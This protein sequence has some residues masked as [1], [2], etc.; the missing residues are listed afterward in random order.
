MRRIARKTGISRSAEASHHQIGRKCGKATGKQRSD[1]DLY[2]LLLKAVAS[3]AIARKTSATAFDSNEPCGSQLI[4]VNISGGRSRQTVLK[5]GREDRSLGRGAFPYGCDLYGYRHHRGRGSRLARGDCGGRGRPFAKPV[6]TLQSLPHAQPHGCRRRRGSR[7]DQGRRQPRLSFSRHRVGRRLAVRSG[8]GR[9]VREY[10]STRVA[11][12]GPLGLSVEPRAQRQ[13]GG[14]PIRRDEDRTHMVCS[15][16]ERLPYAAH[17]VPDFVEISLDPAFRRI[18]RDRSLGRR[19]T[20]HR[21]SRDRNAVGTH[22]WLSSQ[23]G[24]HRHRR[25]RPYLPL[26]HQRRDQDR[27]GM[28]MAYRAGVPL[29]DM[30]FIQYHPTGLPGTGILMTEGSRGEGGLLIN[31]DGYRYLQDYGL[32]PPDPWPRL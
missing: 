15:R 25:L 11:A 19:W 21:C 12:N 20:L 5:R 18:L 23:S 22:G 7:R 27:D 29:K 14:A 8:R 16:P 17:A 32:G 10:G 4:Q 24:D 2:Q 6:P 30:E 3:G 31:K 28:A 26:H 9:A 13:G 1:I